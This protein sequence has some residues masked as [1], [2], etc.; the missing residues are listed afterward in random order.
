MSSLIGQLD[1]KRVPNQSE[2]DYFFKEI[3]E[4]G[5]S[6]ECAA[7]EAINVFSSEFDISSIF[8]YKNS[9]ELELKNKLETC[10]L[11]LEKAS[12]GE[13]STVHASFAIQ[14][15]SQVL[16]SQ[17]TTDQE[18]ISRMC[19]RLCENRGLLFTMIRY[20]R[21]D[22][23][24][25]SSSE[26]NDDVPLGE[27]IDF[28]EED[29]DDNS[30]KSKMTLQF[31]NSYIR[32][33]S[34]SNHFLNTEIMLTFDEEFLRILKQSLDD[35]NEDIEIADVFIDFLYVVLSLENN[36]I[37]FKDIGGLALLEL[38]GRLHKSKEHLQVK[39]RHLLSLL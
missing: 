15:L 25:D 17:K 13:E 35:D 38:T 16:F 27:E 30:L 14:A 4:E 7:E 34:A 1:N 39:I 6:I 5:N 33:G 22:N 31:L 32:L 24:K 26:T 2:F 3:L 18:S 29:D 37:I 20:L 21:V 12:K 28:K 36:R 11:C 9:S 8:I 19:W 10:C 23:D